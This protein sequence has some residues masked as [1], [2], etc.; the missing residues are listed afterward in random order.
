MKLDFSEKQIGEL[1]TALEAI[2]TVFG[3]IAQ[4]DRAD[5]MDEL[6]AILP[7]LLEAIGK[8]TMS[9]RAYIFDL[10]MED[11]KEFCMT[12]EWCDVGVC[13]TR[14][15]LQNIHISRIPNWIKRFEAG[16]PV[17]SLD[18]KNDRRLNEEEYELFEGQNIQS[19]IAFPVFSNQVLK[20]CIGL[21][22]PESSISE[23]SLRL[24]TSVG[25][26]LGNLKEN[27]YMKAMLKEKQQLL[28]KSIRE[29]EEEKKLQDA[30]CVDYTSVYYCDLLE[31]TIAPIK[32]G[33]YT[34]A[35]VTDR[36]LSDAGQGNKKEKY[37]FRIQYYF[38]NF[39]IEESEPE[40][41]EKL[42]LEYLERMFQKQD[43]VA[44]RFQTKPNMAG[45]EYFEVQVVRLKEKKGFHTVMGFR[46]V[47]DIVAE[48]EKQ[49]RELEKAIE[50][51]NLN[52]EIIGSISK[53][54]WLIYR[55]DLLL[56][57][58]EEVS[59]G[60]EIHRLTGKKG[61]I[62]NEFREVRK[63][64]V[65]EKYQ[66]RMKE[67]LDINTL[68]SRLKD[69]E[70]IETEYYTT[71]G[72]WHVASFIVKKR[73]EEGRITNV[74]YVVRN[75]NKQ[76]KQELEYQEKLFEAMEEAKRANSVKTDFLRRM[77]HDIRTPINGI[78]GMIS[79]ADYYPN[80]MV[81][82]QECR[83][84]IM[85][86][87]GFL[88]DLVNDVLDMNK[89]ESGKAVV[90]KKPFDILKILKENN[91][92]IESSEHQKEVRLIADDIEVKHSHLIGSPLHFR[93]II[94]NI[95]GNAL[96][97]NRKGGTIT[98]SCRETEI[99]DQTAQFVIVCSD[100]G[101]G[102]SEEF[103]KHAF[104]PFAQEKNTARTSY[105]GTGLGLSIVKQL[106][107]LMGGTI[108]LE[109]QLDAGTKVTIKI[110][111]LID[112]KY[113]DLQAEK[114]PKINSTIRGAH[115]L[116]AEDNKLNMEIVRFF[117]EKEGIKVTEAHDGEEAVRRFEQSEPDEFDCILMDI[118]MPTM[119]GLEA[120]RCI[121][122]L[123]RSDAKSIP[124]FAMTANTFPEDMEQCK[125]A[126]MNEHIAKPLSES[127]LVEVLRKYIG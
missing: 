41:V 85:E 111:F 7:D 13:T 43:R 127:D 44:Y 76:K 66:E 49:K 58:Y 94:Q 11:Q 72:E 113:H 30:L 115:V 114:K 84:K 59:A 70:S 69:T 67:F 112:E 120:T 92:I 103:V 79:I 123:E 98:I 100:T 118:M 15:E 60:Q 107:E 28:R 12:Y 87:S 3:Y 21:D 64:V 126:G 83:E 57:T 109:S 105:E 56:G 125:E 74:L 20:G 29:I 124:V 34:N 78:R 47:D 99:T 122:E 104:E 77:S 8:Y 61:K 121:R 48:E 93:Q 46:Y 22:N 33:R 89:I 6:E 39:V 10:E 80:D 62:E 63:N 26:H 51:A 17:V 5:S 24:L 88:L 101:C 55:M 90:E 86:A 116:V 25:G 81:K 82:Q 97:Y 73:N 38:E 68:E 18:W 23:I 31:D 52:N 54:Y 2:D 16:E 42:S 102:M 4:L 19:L 108:H 40:F 106:V 91:R 27:L 14:G 96:K 119:G 95:T 9:D 45:Q 37:S 36:I 117:L 110:P 53:K 35:V 65:A 32:Q 75:I 50:S 1:C 71:T